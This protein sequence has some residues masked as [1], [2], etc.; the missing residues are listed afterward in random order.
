MTRRFMVVFLFGLLVVSGVLAGVSQEAMAAEYTWARIGKYDSVYSI[1]WVG[2]DLYAG[3]GNSHV[4]RYDGT[5]WTD[6][7]DAGGGAYV[8]TLAW[9]GANLFAGGW[10]G[11]VYRYDGGTTWNDM[12]S[13]SGSPGDRAINSL[14][15]NGT[16]LY[17]GVQ[18]GRVYRFNGPSNWT[19][20]GATGGSHVYSLG[21]NGTNLFAG[22]GDE[23]PGDTHVYRYN[24]STWNDTGDTGGTYVT[25]LAWNGT[26]MYAGCADDSGGYGHIFRYDD[27]ATWTDV[28]NTAGSAVDCLLWDGTDL[29]AGSYNGH[30]YRYIGGTT[31]SDIGDTGGSAVRSLAWKGSDLYAGCNLGVYRGQAPPSCDWYLAEGTTAWGFFTYITIE[32]PNTSPVQARVTYMP[33][34]ASNKSETITLPAQSQTTLTND[35][36]V[37]LFG[38]ADFSTRVECL[39]ATKSIAVDRTMNWISPIDLEQ[40]PSEHPTDFHSSIGVT[41]PAKSWYLPEGSSAWGFET[42]LLIQN[43]SP[44]TATCQVTY[45]IEGEV[46]QRSTKE[47][48][49]NSRKSYNM[50][51]DIGNKD[52]SIKV[53]SDVPVIPERAMYRNDRAEG[54]DSIGTTTPASD[55]YLA[56]G[57]TAWGFT[58]WVLVQNPNPSACDVTITYMTPEGPKPQAPFS[59]PADSRKTIKVNDVSG[60]GATDFSTAVHGSKPIIAERAMYWDSPAGQKCHDSIGMDSPHTTFWLPDGDA[61]NEY[62]ET[63]TLVQNPN[64]VPV[65]VRVTYLTPSGTGNVTFTDTIGANSRKTYKMNDK[66]PGTRA[67]IAVKS[68][69][70]DKKIMVERAMYWGD[71]RR[72]GTDT[73][74]GYED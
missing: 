65:N 55:Y 70:S 68:E 18:N 39:D 33:S 27:G 60:M 71:G 58:T 5:N 20:T 41:S 16:S 64:S 2:S 35:H 34:G 1:V 62:V 56:E 31:W 47:V 3:C 11:H 69:T 24:G 19:D 23:S 13:P 14:L 63:W 54:H 21:W 73:I 9:N 50:A 46:P 67:A 59:M 37:S 43:P 6:T 32:N 29:F 45:M 40:G 72:A 12:G 66:I 44:T 8:Y 10:N 74:G 17:A 22:C 61:T 57:T 51:S 49:A 36:L 42:W 28:G 30:V 38:L 25:T 7:G 52:A 26:N 4:Y 48:P 53:I 15:Y